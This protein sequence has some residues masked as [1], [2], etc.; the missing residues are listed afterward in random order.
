M[1]R[2]VQDMVFDFVAIHARHGETKDV[3][4]AGLQAAD[5]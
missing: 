4:V 5:Y 1:R 3:Q 2:W